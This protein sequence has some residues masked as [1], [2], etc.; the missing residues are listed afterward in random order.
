MKTLLLLS[1]VLIFT[2]SCHNK[3]S[4]SHPDGSRPSIITTVAQ[5]WITDE[6]NVSKELESI[7]LV[8]QA[9][10]KSYGAEKISKA[11]DEKQLSILKAS[12]TKISEIESALAPQSD[13]YRESAL[14]FFRKVQNSKQSL[15]EL[16]AKLQPYCEKDHKTASACLGGSNAILVYINAHIS[17]YMLIH[18]VLMLGESAHVGLYHTTNNG[19]DEDYIRSTDT[20][21]GKSAKHYSEILPTIGSVSQLESTFNCLSKSDIKTEVGEKI[22]TTSKVIFQLG[23]RDCLVLKLEIDEINKKSKENNIN[24]SIKITEPQKS[25]CSSILKD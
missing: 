6:S 10:Y 7:G 13:L 8:Y 16:N 17:S 15:N 12:E 25:F 18:P 21:A 5:N 22:K 14:E 3:K 19:D 1:T 20:N 24:Y 11:C 9:N 2:I 4:D 23:R